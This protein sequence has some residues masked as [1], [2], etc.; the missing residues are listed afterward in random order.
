MQIDILCD[1]LSSSDNSPRCGVVIV[2]KIIVC[3]QLDVDRS[4]IML[5]CLQSHRWIWF[6]KLSVMKNVVQLS[7]FALRIARACCRVVG[8]QLAHHPDI[9]PTCRMLDDLAR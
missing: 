4:H 6:I 1:H 5:L 2:W 7:H 3:S 9:I 8:A